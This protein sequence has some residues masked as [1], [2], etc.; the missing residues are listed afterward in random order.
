MMRRF[1]ALFSGN[2]EYETPAA[3][4]RGSD[5]VARASPDLLSFKR[6][7]I[8][9][10]GVTAGNYGRTTPYVYNAV[11]PLVMNEPGGAGYVNKSNGTAGRLVDPAFLLSQLMKGG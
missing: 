2:M 3:P 5:S 8:D 7:E 9:G 1:F 10:A 11:Q 6:D 4:V